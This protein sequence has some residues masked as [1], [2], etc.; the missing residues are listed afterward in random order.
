MC[1]ARLIRKRD[2]SEWRR[3]HHQRR[4]PTRSQ[5]LS[6]NT[7]LYQRGADAGGRRLVGRLDGYATRRVSR[8]A[9]AEVDTPNRP[10]D[11]TQGRASRMRALLRRLRSVL[12]LILSGRLPMAFRSAHLFSADVEHRASHWC[13]RR[14]TGA[15][16][17]ILGATMG[18][19]TT[20]AAAGAVGKVRR[21]PMAM[22]PFCGYHM[23][24]YFRHW[25]TMQRSLGSTPQDFPRQLVPQRC[26][27][28]FYLAG[29]QPEHARTCAGWWTGF[30]AAPRQRSHPS[31]G[32]LDMRI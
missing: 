3:G 14:L 8:L 29:F 16:A 32:F 30:I 15:R 5:T 12:R 6:K 23:G 20:A 1:C 4:I 10:A 19:E 26:R 27:R 17:F 31:A 24:D 2:F 22:L 13:F 9:R 11:W 25:L 7:Y 28:R 21:D 18:S